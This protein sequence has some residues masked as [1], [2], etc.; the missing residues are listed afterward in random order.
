MPADPPLTAS[1]RVLAPPQHGPDAPP[2]LRPPGAAPV[3]RHLFGKFT[4]H[5]GRNVYGG[6][7]AQIVPN[8][9]FAPAGLWPN[10]GELLRRL[11]AAGTEF[12]LPAL[13]A[14]LA[15]DLPPWWLAEG[16][17]RLDT[18]ERRGRL[19]PRIVAEG[20]GA[21]RLITPL[22][23]PAHRTSNYRLH[24]HVR[25]DAPLDVSL[26]LA[27]HGTWASGRIAPGREW[28]TCELALSGASV[29]PAGAPFHLVLEPAAAGCLELRRCLLFPA[30]HLD[31]WD[32][33]VVR[34]MREARLP[35]LRFPGGNFASA[36]HWRDGVGPLEDRPMLPNPAWPEAEWNHVGTDE[37]LRL[38]E[39]AGCAPLICVNAG[40]GTPEESADWVEYCNGAV[41]TPLGALRALNGHSEPYGVRLW[42]VGNE[43]YGS[44]Q[45]GATDSAG[46]AARYR[47]HTSAMLARDPGIRLIANGDTEA[48]NR[49]VVFGGGQHVRSLSHHC[50][51]G[52]FPDDAEPL[53]VY[54]EHMAF[55]PA[56]RRMWEDLTRPMREAGLAPRLAITEQQLF[57]KRPHLPGNDTLAEA[58]WDASILNEAIRAGDLVE[59]LTHSALI[60]H[61]AGLRK[62]REVVY[63]Q[64]AWWTTHLY[65][66]APAPLYRLELEVDTPR[67]GV[68]PYRLPTVPDAPYLDAVAL[69]DEAG[70][71]LVF[72]L[73]NRHPDA[74][75]AVTL[76][77]PAGGF[78]Q[79]EIHTLSGESYMA[80]NTADRP[81]TVRPA[82]QRRPWN[83]AEPL[84]LPPC[85]LVRL[86]LLP[87][88]GPQRENAPEGTVRP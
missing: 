46:Y 86:H 50:L 78:E 64:P 2:S 3:N 31:G 53:R 74:P 7:W 13:A 61:G 19:V 59:M 38:C 27:G 54:L 66:G 29:P 5:L 45:V 1:V 11:Q 82:V 80:R 69:A 40:D 44:W 14:A 71:E 83:P 85:S 58:I 39:L 88:A 81:D 41:T 42:E 8:P 57:T 20:A 21:G 37:W 70:T 43:L 36:Y 79:A 63:A 26:R 22:H 24:L 52:G 23:L 35:L 16:M 84:V 17:L 25:G 62:E 15:G 56:Y 33:D 12:G 28:A 6:A 10:R 34:F 32:P 73:I 55:T 67:F 47:R 9:G 87:A 49:T 75:L 68:E 76:A 51:Y 60:N 65:A 48:W 77:L 72:F 30:D 4:E 18:A